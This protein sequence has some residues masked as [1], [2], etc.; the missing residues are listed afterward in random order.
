MKNIIKQI[1]SFVLPI[2]VLIIVPLWIEKNASVLISTLVIGIFIMC[3]GLFIMILTISSFVRIGKGTL[4]PWN[5]TKK[6]VISGLYAYV[7][8]PMIIAVLIVLIGE[9]IAVLS[10]N[11]FIWTVIFF[12]INNI[13]FL[14]YEE[15]NLER[16]FKDEYRDYKGSVPRWVPNLKPFKSDLDK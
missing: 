11:I 14:V 4:A 2:T 8:N 7:R 10:L 13:Y 15:P 5:P 9:S 6:I 12:V 16:R 1:I 3:I